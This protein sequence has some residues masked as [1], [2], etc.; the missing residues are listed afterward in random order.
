MT[1]KSL[2]CFAA[3]LA[4]MVHPALCQ[5]SPLLGAWTWLS[6]GQGG[7]DRNTVLFQPDGTYV[8]ASQLVN[9]S[10]LRYWGSYS[11]TQLSPNQVN[12]QSHTQGWLPTSLCAQAPGFPPRCSPAPHPPE[13]SFNLVFTS[14]ST[15]QTQGVV[16]SRD[17]SPYL[18]RQ[19]VA[20]QQMMTVAAPVQPNIQQPV[21]PTLHPYVT[22]NGPG[23]Q[24]ANA[25]H[26]GAQRF[27]NENMR[28]CYTG[29]DGRLYGCQQ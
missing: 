25:N 14:P 24:I 26:A 18:L 22:P 11:V 10:M 27:I 9:G 17:P 13:M 28:G 23:N 2:G 5:P 4:A 3:A 15:M 29:T 1:L 20:Q 12:L 8:R 16:L 19:Q 21:M 7:M 6:P